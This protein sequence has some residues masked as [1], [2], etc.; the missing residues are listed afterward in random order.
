MKE[1]SKRI[2]STRPQ[3]LLNPYY[4]Q[5]VFKKVYKSRNVLGAFVPHASKIK[6]GQITTFTVMTTLVDL[7]NMWEHRANDH[8]NMQTNEKVHKNLE[9]AK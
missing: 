9:V 2:L 7:W 3:G 1:K 6:K 5:N 8:Q 4:A